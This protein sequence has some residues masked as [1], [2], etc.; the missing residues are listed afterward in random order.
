MRPNKL[1]MAKTHKFK[2]QFTLE[3]AT[4]RYKNAKRRA[5]Y[6]SS[7]PGFSGRSQ[8]TRSSRLWEKYEIAMFDCRSWEKEIEW[9]TGV[10]QEHYDPKMS[11]R[12]VF[13]KVMNSKKD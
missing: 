2:S 4:R 3:E 7:T 5:L 1:V 13:S 9:I 8:E 11:F 10:V 12:R 6:Y